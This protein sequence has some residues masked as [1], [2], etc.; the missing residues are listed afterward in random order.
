M[1]CDDE[2][3]ENQLG[4]RGQVPLRGKK[5]KTK[6]RCQALWTFKLNQVEY[7]NHYI[8][9]EKELFGGG[10]HIRE[11]TWHAMPMETIAH[12]VEK[13]ICD[14]HPMLHV[15]AGLAFPI[16]ARHIPPGIAGIWLE[17]TNG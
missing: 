12:P 3:L 10:T 4:Q 5:K 6:K 1:F 14:D 7:D 2:L 9:G 16:H 15:L 13:S 8:S 17:T 11:Y